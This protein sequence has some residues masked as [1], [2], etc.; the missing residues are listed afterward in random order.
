M[1]IKN[2]TIVADEWTVLRLSEQDS[3]ETVAV[4]AGKV[5][6]PLQ[7]W[8][9]QRDALQQRSEIGVW[10]ATDERPEVL[11]EDVDKFSVIAVNFPK[12]SDGR[13][14]SIA[15]N[16][17]TRLGFSGE[18]RAMGDV[19]RDQLFYMQRVGFDAFAPRPDRSIED[20]L[21]GL[22]DFSDVYQTSFD[23]K[24]PLFRR[25]QR[26]GNPAAGLIDE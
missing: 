7:V 21:K 4:P 16:L 22:S 9:Q 5:I 25:V 17:R 14:Y 8:L 13:G 18:L 1:I 12:F 11:K 10:L 19:L 24:Q 26:K 2:R 6:V 20:A 23:Q 15:Y 3:P